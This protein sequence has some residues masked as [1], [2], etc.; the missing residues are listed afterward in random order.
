VMQDV[1]GVVKEAADAVPA[2]ITHDRTS[3]R[4][5]IFL[6]GCADCAGSNAR[7]DRSDPAHETFV[8]H[9]EQPLRRPANPP[10]GV[11][12][13]G[14]AVPSVEDVGYIDI[15]DIALA[16]RL[17]VRNSVTDHVIDGG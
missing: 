6:D 4:F 10:D 11:H 12:P 17:L 14:I 9:L 13:A 7:P 5:C 3:L 8:R 16:Q 1:R 2:E 15:D